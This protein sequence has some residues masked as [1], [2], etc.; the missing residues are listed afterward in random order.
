M[1]ENE[2]LY[3]FNNLIKNIKFYSMKFFNIREVLKEKFPY[4]LFLNLNLKSNFTDYLAV[5]NEFFAS[6]NQVI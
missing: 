2:F 1:R 4:F 5:P 6:Q 3:E